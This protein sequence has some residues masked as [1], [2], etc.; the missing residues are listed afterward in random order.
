[1]STGVLE[2]RDGWLFLTGG[3]NVVATLYDRQS[4]L[5]SDAKLQQW[6]DL[7]EARARRLEAMGIQYVHINI[8]CKLTIYDHKL[9]QPPMIDWT[10]SPA[11]RLGELVRRSDH[12]RVWLDLTEPFRAA[13][14]QQRLYYRT[15]SHWTAE[16]CFLAYKLLCEK[17]GI[18]A[19]PSLLG[20]RSTEV[21]GLLD[22]GS[23]MEPPMPE[24]ISVYN[25]AQD[26]V[27]AYA[28]SVAKYLEVAQADAKVHVGSHV[29]YRN[30]SPGAV[31]KKILIFG[32]SYSNTGQGA[33]TGMLAETVRDAEFI[34][35]SNFDWSYIRRTR[36]DVVIYELVE[37]FMTVLAEDRLSL[38]LISVRQ[39]LRANWLRLTARG[40]AAPTKA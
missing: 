3:S 30:D 17:I 29:R 9:N 14:D 11:V 22:L 31:K 16:G 7:M 19:V 1:M 10:L 2:G 39:G 12:A 38:R 36:P 25:Y 28:N 8:P 27:L 35:S 24:H 26:S 33:L 20:R 13:R 15:D 23:K 6:A 34:W 32:D 21:H 37:R 18:A 4:F 40:T 5:L